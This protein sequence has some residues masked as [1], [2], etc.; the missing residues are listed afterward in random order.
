MLGAVPSAPS[1]CAAGVVCHNEGSSGPM[2]HTRQQL[3][4]HSHGD[5]PVP[6]LGITRTG[7][8]AYAMCITL[9]TSRFGCYIAPLQC[10]HITHITLHQLTQT[11]RMVV[12]LGFSTA[13]QVCLVHIASNGVSPCQTWHVPRGAM[14]VVP[15][16]SQACVLGP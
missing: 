5:P 10:T 15:W 12:T 6:A 4:G 14:C 9:C 7:Q 2:H 1:T 11:A 13:Q 3:H 16:R 8:M